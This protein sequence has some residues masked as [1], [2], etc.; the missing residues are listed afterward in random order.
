[1]T[2]VF[3][4]LKA[5]DG[6]LFCLRIKLDNFIKLITFMKFNIYLINIIILKL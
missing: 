2:R 1:M 5:T 3:H 4:K 6:N